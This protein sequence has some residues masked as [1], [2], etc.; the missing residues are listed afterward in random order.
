M[1]KSLESYTRWL[2][3]SIP[4]NDQS[5]G[6]KYTDD[7]KSLPNVLYDGDFAEPKTS[8]VLPDGIYVSLFSAAI[9]VLWGNEAAAVVKVAH[10]DPSLSIPPCEDEEM[11]NGNKWC[12][13][14][15]DAYLLLSWPSKT[16]FNNPWDDNL[17]GSFQ[18]LKGIDKL[19]DYRMSIETVVKAS[20]NAASLNDG[21]PYYEWDPEKVI[22]HMAKDDANLEQFAAFNLPFCDLGTLAGGIDDENCDGEV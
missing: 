19:E 2:L 10:D 5:K 8:D 13:D 4:E 20:E 11:F 1:Q 7:P 6:V 16:W 21:N 14:A 9:S 18:D 12:N 22:D 15:G 3:T 17:P